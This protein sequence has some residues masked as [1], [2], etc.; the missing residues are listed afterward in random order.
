M[1]SRVTDDVITRE[2]RRSELARRLIL[3]HVRTLTITRL[4]GVTRNR[5]AT[6]RRRLMVSE[7][8]RRRGPPP[9]S[10]DRFL[11]TPHGRT[12]G[13]A[14]VVL[15][16]LFDGRADC[17]PAIVPE[18]FTTLDPGE[19]LCDAYEAYR[20]WFPQSDVE[21]EEVLLL[22][23]GVATG[24][25][26]EIGKCRG[27]KALILINRFANSE[28]TCWHCELRASDPPQCDAPRAHSEPQ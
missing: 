3:H 6:L 4:T 10:L 16:S 25:R 1:D 21:L 15:C 22:K 14:I 18:R 26:V 12:E 13:A 28:R 2:N 17:I 8:E 24:K 7:D 19:Q 9:R 11:K 20:A 23:N 27:C 5:L